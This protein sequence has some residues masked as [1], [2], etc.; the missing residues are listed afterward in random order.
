[1][2]TKVVRRHLWFLPISKHGDFQHIREV[3]RM[4]WI[5]TMTIG[6]TALFVVR[7]L[8]KRNTPITPRPQLEN[9]SKLRPAL[10]SKKMFTQGRGMPLGS[11]GDV[12]PV[13]KGENSR[14]GDIAEFDREFFSIELEADEFVGEQLVNEVPEGKVVKDQFDPTTGNKW[15]EYET[16]S[17]SKIVRIFNSWGDLLEVQWSDADPNS[18][19]LQRRLYLNGELAS[20]EISVE[21]NDQN[22]FYYFGPRGHVIEKSFPSNSSLGERIAV[23]YDSGGIPIAK[24][25]ETA[26]GQVLWR[27]IPGP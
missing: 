3:L 7:S 6:M 11:F 2:P 1:M 8:S 12:N 19:A 17:G 20:I 13:S 9:H 16:E 21:R 26:D 4:K 25:R 14:R 24:R 22:I 27:Q 18:G 10:S 15:V 23:S 5:L